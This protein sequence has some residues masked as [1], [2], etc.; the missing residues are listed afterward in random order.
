[1][2]SSFDFYALARPFFHSLDPERAHELALWAIERG[3]VPPRSPTPDPILASTFLGRVLSHPL[4]LAAGFDKN[5]RV[6]SRMFGQGF[7]F[8][9]VGGVTL[10]PQAGNQRP[11]VF[12]LPAERAIINRMG[13]PNDGAE[14]VAAR[15]RERARFP[16]GARSGMLG[17]NIASNATSRDPVGDFAR[18]IEQFVPLCDF[19]TLDISCP[20][21]EKGQEFLEPARLE[22]LLTS[23]NGLGGGMV[24]RPLIAKLSPDIEDAR[25]AELLEVLLRGRIA[26]ICMGNTTTSHAHGERG[27]LSGRPLFELSTR[28]L[29]TV[30][31]LVG[32]SLPLIGTGGIRSGADAYEKIRAG[33]SVLQLYTAMIY[34]GPGVVGRILRE[35][36]ELLRRGGFSSIGEAVGTGSISNMQRAP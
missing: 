11:R 1:M 12:R 19:I 16:Q 2:P 22:G 28:K 33:A 14:V 17:V 35:L 20:N 30:R 7:S 23:L 4:G 26:A 10:I 9:E 32:N 15:L 31:R 6:A 5:A 13:L 36:A 34:D 25:L 27:G 21:T 18:L 3:I 8:V 29:A 24:G